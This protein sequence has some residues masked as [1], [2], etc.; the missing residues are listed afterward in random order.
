MLKTIVSFVVVVVVVP[1]LD[2]S[3]SSDHKVSLTTES[4]RDTNNS[5]ESDFV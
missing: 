2:S 5:G 3:L 1:V 4:L